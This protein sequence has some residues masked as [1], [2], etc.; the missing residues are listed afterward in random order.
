MLDYAA[1]VRE[2]EKMAKLSPPRAVTRALPA[3]GEKRGQCLVCGRPGRACAA[4]EGVS[5]CGVEH[6]QRDARWHDVVCDALRELR[7]DRAAPD[8]TLLPDLRVMRPWDEYE[9]TPQRRRRLSDLATRPFTLR[10]AIAALGVAAKT[11]HVMAASQRE[12]D[13][14]K[15]LWGDLN[16]TLVGP[17]LPAHAGTRALYS[18][19]LWSDGAPDLVIG[20]DAGLLMYPSWKQTILELRG[21]GVPFV[22]T[23]YRDWE[24]EAEAKL[25]TAVRARCLLPP[26][27]NPWASRVAKRSTTIANDVSYDNAW[28]SAWA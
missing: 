8:P 1:Q 24:A 15:E 25:L 7:D 5:Y 22:I 26:R 13:V 2:L 27:P 23:T 21:S 3:L 28:V 17:E 16:V 14:P 11:V 10:S 9:G 20:F 12:A 18:R 19:A 4:C 6:Q